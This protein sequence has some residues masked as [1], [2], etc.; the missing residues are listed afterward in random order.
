MLRYFIKPISLVRS[1]GHIPVQPK[2]AKKGIQFTKNVSH[3][4]APPFST[5]R[6]SRGQHNYNQSSYQSSKYLKY[7]GIILGM[8]AVAGILYGLDVYLHGNTHFLPP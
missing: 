4:I 3:S 6:F 7:G 1:A 8:G 5:F 2:F